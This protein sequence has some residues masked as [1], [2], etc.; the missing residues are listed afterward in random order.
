VQIGV[1]ADGQRRKRSYFIEVDRAGE[2][3]IKISS[4]LPQY[5]RYRDYEQPNGRIFPQVLFL[6]PHPRQVA[7]LDRLI[8][9]RAPQSTIFYVGLF[10]DALVLLLGEEVPRSRTRS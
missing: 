1:E 10:D 6:A 5:L 2:W 9:T 7:Y 3:G 4:K 8:Q